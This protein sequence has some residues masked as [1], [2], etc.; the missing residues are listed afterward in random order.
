[1]AIII[2]FGMNAII[3]KTPD[4][5]GSQVAEVMRNTGIMDGEIFILG[6]DVELTGNIDNR[7]S[8]TELLK[9]IKSIKGVSSV[10][11][12]LNAVNFAPPVIDITSFA[13]KIQI[14][15]HLPSSVSPRQFQQKLES[16]FG[17]D[18]VTNDI[19][20]SDQVEAI[21]WVENIDV[22]IEIIGI[23]DPGTI[24]IRGKIGEI[25]GVTLSS[26][27]KNRVDD[28]LASLGSL[29]KI[30]NNIRSLEQ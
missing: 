26:E 19:V 9:Q 4:R 13:G 28:L 30:V 2:A 15:G 8:R 12:R 16:I 7:V 23:V 10:K 1:M 22:I 21:D 18:S 24:E 17:E 5:I 14:Q 3:K 27:E 29:T 25:R 20:Y 6:G 11:D